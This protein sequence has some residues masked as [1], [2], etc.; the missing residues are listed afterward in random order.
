MTP[1]LQLALGKAGAL[2]AMAF[3]AMGSGLGT[4]AAGCS[5]VGAWKRCFLQKKPAPFQLA[6][7]VGAPLSQTI[8]G[9]IIMLIINALLGDKANLANWPLYLF[10][11]ITAGI[12]MG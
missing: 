10:G 9:M 6:V 8:Y 12:A 11:G 7:F 1:E 2:A 3:A 4:G 5:A